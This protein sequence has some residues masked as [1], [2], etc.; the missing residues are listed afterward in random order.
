MFENEKSWR[1]EDE[2]RDQLREI[3]EAM[4]ACVARGIRQEGTLPG[5][6]QIKAAKLRGVDSQGMLCSA[7]ELGIDDDASGLLEFPAGTLDP[8]ET[9]LS[10]M[11][12]ELQEE[13]G[14]SAERWDPLGAML[15]CPGYSDEV[16]HLFL[17]RNLQPL[18][19]PVAADHD[20][21]IEVLLMAPAE[22]DAALASGAEPLDGKSVTAWFRAKQLLGLH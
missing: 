9:P 6:I 15:P 13:A 22:L 20:E 8:G 3:W 5:G 18:A 2:I 19:T 1:S 11:Q 10:T 12:R 14:Y 4:Q 17:A 7:K 21:D 16:I